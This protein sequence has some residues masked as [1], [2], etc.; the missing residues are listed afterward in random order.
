M[1]NLRSLLFYFFVIFSSTAGA[2]GPVFDLVFDLDWTLFYPTKNRI[3]TETISL[4]EDHYRLADGVPEVLIHLHRQGHRISIFSG[5]IAGRNQALVDMILEKIRQKGISDFS[6]YKILSRHD[7]TPRPGVSP[8][9]KFADKWIK[10][11]RKVNPDLRRVVHIDDS[12]KFTLSGQE[13]NLYLL[14]KTYNFQSH[15]VLNPVPDEFDP[16]TQDEWR[17]ER[18]KIQIFAD[19]FQQATGSFAGQDPLLELQGLRQKRPLCQR[20]FQ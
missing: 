20:V 7:L 2:Q 19:H 15:F 4:S 18:R 13:R 5:G 9:A 8:Q 3:D 6:F 14:E 10:D 11:L 1:Q 17:K 12:S 16:P